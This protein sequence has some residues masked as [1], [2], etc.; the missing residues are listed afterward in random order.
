MWLPSERVESVNLIHCL[1]GG[2]P[3]VPACATGDDGQPAIPFRN[4][5]NVFGVRGAL[6]SSASIR[7]IGPVIPLFEGCGLSIPDGFWRP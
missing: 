2:A 3:V 1:G 7:R 6:P 5:S 4:E